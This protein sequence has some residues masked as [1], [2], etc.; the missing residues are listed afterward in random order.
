MSETI[1]F[2]LPQDCPTIRLVQLL[3]GLPSDIFVRCTLRLRSLYDDEAKLPYKA[4]SYAW[5]NRITDIDVPIICND[6]AV[7]VSSNLRDA[8]LRIRDPEISVVLWIDALCINQ[9]DDAER[10]Q[11]V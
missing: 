5:K 8:L 4:L 1:Y 10:T 9:E 11:Q 3:P 7:Q 2:H 6:R